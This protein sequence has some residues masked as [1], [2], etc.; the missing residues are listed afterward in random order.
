VSPEAGRALVLAN[1][2]GGAFVRPQAWE[3]GLYRPGEQ[4]ALFDLAAGL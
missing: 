1:V 4:M 3:P 2:G